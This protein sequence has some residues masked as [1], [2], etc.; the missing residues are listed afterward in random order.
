MSDATLRDRM[1]ELLAAF[2]IVASGMSWYLGEPGVAEARCPSTRST[3]ARGT[4]R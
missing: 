3:L 1:A 2:S 4:R